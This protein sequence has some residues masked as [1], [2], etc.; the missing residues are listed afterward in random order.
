MDS[1]HLFYLVI[2]ISIDSWIFIVQFVQSK[3]TVYYTRLIAPSSTTVLILLLQL[4]QL[5][6][7]RVLSVDSC[8]PVTYPTIVCARVGVC[9]WALPSF[10]ALQNAPGSSYIFPSPIMSHVSKESGNFFGEQY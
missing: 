8:V 5:W 1:S 4:F 9:P 3:Y 7:L 2:C 6:A 10:I